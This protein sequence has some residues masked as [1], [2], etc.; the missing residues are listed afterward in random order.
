[1]NEP[2]TD[3]QTDLADYRESIHKQL[4]IH[5]ASPG[6]WEANPVDESEQDWLFEIYD[7]DTFVT[8]GA[9]GNGNALAIVEAHNNRERELLSQL[10][11]MEALEKI[12]KHLPAEEAFMAQSTL[13][14][15]IAAWKESQ[16]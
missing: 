15:I 16:E 14:K 3:L 4:A 8:T 1:M 10:A 11:M 13:T 2:N 5:R 9:L 6:K 12:A 7:G